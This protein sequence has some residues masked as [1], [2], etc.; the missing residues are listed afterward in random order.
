MRR[1]SEGAGQCGREG[2]SW[3]AN[4]EWV[5]C[6]RPVLTVGIETPGGRLGAVKSEQ[7]DLKR[8]KSRRLGDETS[9]SHR[10]EVIGVDHRVLY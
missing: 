10:R 6:K 1:R 5:V 3:S 4:S 8:R 7:L 2:Y 9:V